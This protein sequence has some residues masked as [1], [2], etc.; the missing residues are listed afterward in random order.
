[1]LKKLLALLTLPEPKRAGVLIG[2]ILM[3]AFLVMLGM[4]SILP[5]MGQGI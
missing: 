3:M 4:A 1:M 2:M 5:F